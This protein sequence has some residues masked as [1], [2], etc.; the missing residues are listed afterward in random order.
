MGTR[1]VRG[2]RNSARN[3]S[4]VTSCSWSRLCL[5]AP[6]GH[7]VASM[8]SPGVSASVQTSWISTGGLDDSNCALDHRRGVGRQPVFQYDN[9]RRWAE[10]RSD[11]TCMASTPLLDIRRGIAGHHHY[12]PL[13]QRKRPI[14]QVRA[15][16]PSCLWG[17]VRDDT[18]SS[19]S[20]SIINTGSNL[21]F[22]GWQCLP[23]DH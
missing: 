10:S 4:A 22:S 16:H 5:L 1:M 15:E 23:L 20:Y 7:E 21:R 18:I 13:P 14:P 8:G 12:P 2:L 19:G 3:I 9:Q 6:L 11:A 17:V